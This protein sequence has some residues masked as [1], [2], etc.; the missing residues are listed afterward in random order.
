MLQKSYILAKVAVLAVFVMCASCTNEYENSND[1]TDN[2][3]QELHSKYIEFS[4]KPVTSILDLALGKASIPRS[5]DYILG[6]TEED[7]KYLNSLD[8]NGL[9][10]LKAQLMNKWDFESDEDID[11]ILEQAYDE[12]CKNMS[13]EE[14]IKFNDFLTKY[15]EMAGG[16]ASIED[17]NILQ[18]NITNSSFN[19]TCIYA[20][21]GIDNFGRIFYNS[22]YN[23]R[24]SADECQKN[25]AIRIAIT[26]VGTMAGMIIPGPGW[27]VAAA[28]ICDAASAAADYANCLKRG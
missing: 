11:A 4:N 5:N 21:I 6:L 7:V 18:S 15:I 20:A 27:A 17:L 12:I 10:D 14:Q 9:L 2:V 3:S 19:N 22:L 23:S 1:T 28:A 26:S 8:V 25:F 24:A 16:M 13:T